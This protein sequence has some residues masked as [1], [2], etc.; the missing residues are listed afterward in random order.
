MVHAKSLNSQVRVSQSTEKIFFVC[1]RGRHFHPA[2]SAV[3]PASLRNFGN[4]K[5]T[6]ELVYAPNSPLKNWT[7]DDKTNIPKSPPILKGAR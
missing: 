7:I 2:F 3:I 6:D 1:R 4:F 5:C